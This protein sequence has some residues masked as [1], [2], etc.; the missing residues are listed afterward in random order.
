[1]P[2]TQASIARDTVRTVVSLAIP[3]VV[4]V[5]TIPV[6]VTYLGPERFGLLGL[7]WA[8]LG[9]FTLLDFG[10]ARATTKLVAESLARGDLSA[11]GSLVA[12]A[13]LSQAGI[14]AAA[15]VV[16]LWLTPWALSTALSVP[17]ALIPEATAAFRLLAASLP[18]VMVS[19]GLRAALEGTQRFDLAAWIRAPS[20]SANFLLT[21][22]IAWLGGG[23]GT[24]VAALLAARAV[25]CCAT[26]AAILRTVPGS[27][28]SLDGIGGRL[29][30]L[31]R[32][33]AW[34][35]L[36]N[37][38]IPFFLYLDR[39]VLGSL[40]GLAA[41]AYYTG[42]YEIVTRLLIVPAGLATVL[43]PSFSAIAA[44]PNRLPEAASLLR[45]SVRH[46]VL[47]LAPPTILLMAFAP[48]LLGLWLGPAYGAHGTVAMRVLAAGVF[49]NAISHVPNSYLMGLGRP[50]AIAKL[51]LLQLPVH[52]VVTWW[53]VARY[54]VPGAA[55]AWAIRATLDAVLLTVLALRSLSLPIGGLLTALG[56][57][58]IA[59]VGVFA[60]GAW[61]LSRLAVN[62]VIRL[63]GA[64]LWTAS[65]LPWAWSHV[66]SAGERRWLKGVVGAQ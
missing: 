49:A 4:G 1:M 5:V 9:Y 65:F 54:G 7:I 36:S 24:M 51:H 64:V 42:P 62:P 61:A 23:L 39:F 29:P 50:D 48:D 30:R 32:Y 21:A 25:T 43:L 6:I 45:A 22:V 11:A 18:L 34:V 28:W 15:G 44:D 10:L 56:P 66:L 40:S 17:P 8:V 14:G 59:A 27:A 26:V 2:G 20:G 16:T 31:V 60:G 63:V 46:L 37:C 57:M 12:A 33:G 13:G 52:G 19:Q 47:M 53:L 3:L 35:A 58:T 55:L 41:V 38:A